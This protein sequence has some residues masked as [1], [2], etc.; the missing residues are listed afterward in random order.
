MNL[1]GCELIIE[2]TRRCNELCPHCLRGEPQKNSVTREAIAAVFSQLNY[3]RSITFTGGE[4]SLAPGRIT[5]ALEAA[6]VYR[7]EVGSFYVVTNAKQYSRPFTR[8]LEGWLAWCDNNETSALSISGDQYHDGGNEYEIS[9]YREWAEEMKETY[10]YFEFDKRGY[11]QSVIR[12]GRAVNWGERYTS[13]EDL[14]YD[15]IEDD[16]TGMIYL[17][18]KGEILNGCDY[19]YESQDSCVVCR[20]E[21]NIAEAMAEKLGVKECA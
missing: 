13:S 18:A 16:F 2:V 3:V 17:N 4:P 15:R 21:D 14:E 12:E 6:R 19:S 8:A 1:N 9:L 7:V 10:P 5:M 20:A 11:I